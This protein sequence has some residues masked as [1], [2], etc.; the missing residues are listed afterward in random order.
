M[1]RSILPGPLLGCAAL[2]LSMMLPTGL[3]AARANL[4][5][6]SSASSL[7]LPVVTMAATQIGWALGS[8]MGSSQY[9]DS[10]YRTTDGGLRWQEATPPHLPT[11]QKALVV[12]FAGPE[13]AMVAV[14]HV[15]LLTTYVTTDGG[16]QWH[17]SSP[18]STEYPNADLFAQFVNRNDGFLE[19][20]TGGN[21]TLYGALLA[22]KNGGETW[23]QVASDGG[24]VNRVGKAGWLPFSEG[25]A[26]DNAMDGSMGGAARAYSGGNRGPGF[27]WFYDTRD[28]G[29]TWT[30]ARLPVAADDRGA[31]TE[32]SQPQWFGKT[33]WLIVS[34]LT[35]RGAV[36][37]SLYLTQNRGLSW[38]VIPGLPAHVTSVLFVTPHVGYAITAD[39]LYR[40]THSGRSWTLLNQQSTW[41][42]A[43][44]QFVTPSTGWMVWFNQRAH[45]ARTSDGGRTWK[46]Y[47]PREY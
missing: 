31:L 37:T 14:L 10:V 16:R 36:H 5:Q 13:S 3:V 2:L 38:R 19:L 24:P 43:I 28:G 8:T 26:F 22:T 20:S 39:A 21:G 29:V 27:L 17:T 30:H 33:G 11:G 44:V 42:T 45:W 41:N 32:V 7:A 18:L 23:H 1:M 12:G 35:R 15:S 46:S 34:F 47:T 25:F 4:A 9:E 6:E 40:S